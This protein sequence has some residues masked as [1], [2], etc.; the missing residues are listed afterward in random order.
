MEKIFEPFIGSNG[1]YCHFEG[2]VGVGLTKQEAE[3]EAINKYDIAMEKHYM[4]TMKNQVTAE[5]EITGN[6]IHE[7]L[8]ARGRR[9][10]EYHMVA[11]LSQAL[12]E[13]LQVSPSWVHMEPHQQESLE[14]ICNKVSRI[15]N[16][17]PFYVYSWRD[18]AGYAQLVVNE[19]EKS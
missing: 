19:L 6:D 12:K 10:G 16:G 5:M 8:E 3:R 14:M 9:Y 18:I 15:C 2:H 1:W 17:D 11:Q 7:V 4:G 13:E